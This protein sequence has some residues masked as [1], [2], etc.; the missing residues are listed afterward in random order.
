[1]SEINSPLGRRRLAAQAPRIINVPNQEGA[2][3]LAEPQ[4]AP[5][6][7]TPQPRQA[8]RFTPDEL[9]NAR[10][11]A[12]DQRK[13]VSPAA[14]ERIEFLTGLGRARKEIEF[15]GV[16]FSLQSLKASEMRDV[17]HFGSRGETTA[18]A[19]FDIR[20]YTLA[21]AVE[22]IDSQQIGIVLGDDSLDARFDLI[23]R[24]EEET[25]EFLHRNYNE[26][27]KESKTRFEVKTNEE[28]KEVAEEIKK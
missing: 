21:Y 8:P 19:M 14:K 2:V 9:E 11:T 4:F 10:K 17:L 1:M 18:E 24:M 15:E 5:T 13:R 7:S 3:P 25:V 16:V 20:A 22:K 28:A 12:V 27:V 26:M 23:C 6:Q